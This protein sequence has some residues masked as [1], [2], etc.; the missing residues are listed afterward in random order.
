MRKSFLLVLPLF[1]FF[2]VSFAQQKATI[3]EYNKVFTTYPFSDPDPVPEVGKIYPYFR[4]DGYTDKPIQKEWKVVELENDY[5]KVMILPE[6]GGKIWAA[7]EKSTGKS[8]IYYNHAV[9]FRDVA[10]RGPWTSGGLEANYGIIGHTPNCATPVDYTTIERN[11]GSVSCVIG[12][13]DLLTRTSWR[14]DINLQ[15]DKAYFTTSSFWY[16]AS[17]IEQPY[18]TWMN[19]GIKAK[20][21]LE[22]IY[23]GTKY[24]GHEGE[25][26]DWPINKENGKNISFYENNNFGTYK[27]YHVFGKYTDFFGG[28]WHDEDFGMG[29]YSTHDDKPGKKIWIWG[30]SQQGMIWE[31]LLT[32]TDGQYVEVQSG[33]L[34]NQ[35]AEGSTF[36]PFKHKG[37][38]PHTTDVWT[39][40]WFP[41]LKTKGFVAANNYGALNVKQENGWMKI[42]FL[43]LQ[44]ITDELAVR[45]GDKIIY[46]KKLEL[47]TLQ[48]FSDSFKL[49][50]SA[51]DAV[52]TLGKDKLEYDASPQANVLSRPVDTPKDFDWNSVQGLYLQGKEDLR[53][54][55]YTAAEEKLKAC[56]Q[57]D[58]N[59]LPA[60]TDYAM[61]LYRNTRYEEA[62]SAA[63]KALS[64]DTYDPAANY[65]YGIIN[66]ALENTVD[67]KDGF[68]IAA[69]GMEYRSAAYT[70]LAKIYFKENKLDKAIDYAHK[71]IDFNRY[72]VDAY[73]MLAVIYRLQ[74]DQQSANKI[75]DTLLLYDPLN[76]FA[77]F[78]KYLLNNSAESKQQF[79]AMIRNEMPQQTFLEL[80]AWYYNISRRED[81]KKILELSP[82]NAEV[83]YWLAYLD[84]KPLNIDD[85]DP[86][87]VFPF[88]PET[89]TVLKAL[90]QKNDHWLLKYHLALLE[91]NYNNIDAAKMLFDQCGNQSNYAP[92]YAARAKFDLNNDS[93]KVLS[94]LQKAIKLDNK[95]W[96]YGKALINY[97]FSKK[98]YDSALS[99]A[100]KYAKQF[101]ENYL[102]GMLY[103]KALLNNKQY[104]ATNK[105][106]QTIN[107]LPNEGAT[108]GRQLYEETQL[109][110]AL[111]AMQ[112]KNYKQSLNYV[113]AARKWPQNLGV[114]K[115]YESDIDERLEDWLAYENY[116]KLNNEKAAKQML[117]KIVAFSSS[118]KKNRPSSNDLITA[119]SLQKTGR[120]EDAEKFLQ[121]QLNNNP[122]NS[123][124]QWTMNTYKGKD[125]KL[126]TDMS[127]NMHYRVLQQWIVMQIQDHAN[128]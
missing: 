47:K 57:K 105:V 92:F 40:Y 2:S 9:K 113:E 118:D 68:D 112:K 1:L 76:H 23:P 8:F 44:N 42:Y 124:A 37:F 45:S 31:K 58:A 46:S 117:N 67:A 35:S 15:K 33:R 64:I 107:I 49:N 56:L 55:F 91:W 32:D 5:I 95:E 60:L 126:P 17:P 99:V 10:M 104:E 43:P 13:L 121:Q 48:I 97:Y 62:L 102:I 34:F 116:L 80:A 61:L 27:S 65:Y 114:G 100:G 101:P 108:D 19:T 103:A 122:D 110:L 83:V 11:D 39:E 38:L 71:S 88:R 54:R 90:I 93:D 119:W 72:S 106:L 51:D 3:K 115:P 128:R 111:D 78:E 59:Y 30:L 73:K 28:Y 21:N 22:F 127:A 7:I 109:M 66:E 96:R 84:N 94:D 53:Q 70:E 87:L 26:A 69:L 12:V 123:F 77:M 4:F 50:T 36:T 82:S 74:N 125:F 20:G 52:V 63:K 98:Q 29:R 86:S 41:V 75:S 79:V 14:I 81:A 24:L 16:N 25:Y 89:A 6:V 85:V 120:A 18:Y